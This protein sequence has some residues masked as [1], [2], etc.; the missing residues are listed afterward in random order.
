MKPVKVRL[1]H[2]NAKGSKDGVG[3]AQMEEEVGQG[4]LGVVSRKLRDQGIAAVQ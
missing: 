1:P 4:K 3:H 2:V